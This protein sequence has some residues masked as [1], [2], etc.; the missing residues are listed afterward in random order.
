MSDIW[1]KLNATQGTSF[2]PLFFPDRT[3]LIECWNTS[4]CLLHKSRI[5]NIRRMQRKCAKV[6]HTP[7]SR[8]ITEY[9]C[10]PFE[11]LPLFFFKILWCLYFT[12]NIFSIHV[13]LVNYCK[14][15]SATTYMYNVLFCFVLFL[16][17]AR[18][19]TRLTKHISGTLVSRAKLFRPSLR[20]NQQFESIS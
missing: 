11:V 5:T 3:E 13:M 19:V 15:R 1:E 7:R 4:A 14:L 9:L 18:A 17:A 16:N 12:S 6:R 20:D 2:S 8:V 10:L